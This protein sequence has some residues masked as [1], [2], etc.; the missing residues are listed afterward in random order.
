MGTEITKDEA[1]VYFLLESTF[2][3]EIIGSFSTEHVNK[4]F[5]TCPNAILALLAAD[6]AILRLITQDQVTNLVNQHPALSPA[7]LGHCYDVFVEYFTDTLLLTMIS[8]CKEAVEP[9]LMRSRDLVSRG[10]VDKFVLF[11]A[12]EKK[13]EMQDKMLD[14]AYL[15]DFHEDIRTYQPSVT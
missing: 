9:F 12:I 13:P 10:K 3:A 4:I 7:L 8:N 6:H 5:T 15:K 2:N 11:A 1:S 14:Q